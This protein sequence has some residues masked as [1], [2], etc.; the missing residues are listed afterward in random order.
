MTSKDVR[1]QNEVFR[2][3]TPYIL[4]VPKMKRACSFKLTV[5]HLRNNTESQPR[6][7]QTKHSPP[8]TIEFYIREQM[9]E[10]PA[11]YDFKRI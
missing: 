9:T 7:P 10:I 5:V 11:H 4:V 1:N 6:R 2:V 3:V 8:K